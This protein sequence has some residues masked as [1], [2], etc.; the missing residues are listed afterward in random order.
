MNCTRCGHGRAAHKRGYTC[1]VGH[2][3]HPT[4][5]TKPPCVCFRF[6]T[7]P[8]PT[9]AAGFQPKEAKGE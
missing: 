8:F 7:E 6:T 1:Q 3:D 5:Q 4:R 2:H 9:F